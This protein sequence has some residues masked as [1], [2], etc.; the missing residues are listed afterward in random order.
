MTTYNEINV[1]CNCCGNIYEISVIMSYSSASSNFLDN[2][3]ECP[4]CE[5]TD[6]EFPIKE[7]E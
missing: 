2:S 3:E 7:K 1:K 5:K 4:R 6:Y